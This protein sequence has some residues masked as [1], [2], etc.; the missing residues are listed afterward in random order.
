MPGKPLQSVVNMNLEVLAS[1][2]TTRLASPLP[3]DAAHQL[4]R[5]RALDGNFPG[6]T[7]KLPPKPG[8][9][10]ILLYQE[11]DAVRFPIIRRQVYPGAHSGQISLPGGKTERGESSIVTAL[12]E[13]HEEIGVDPDTP[14]VIGA[15]S[16]FF[17]GASNFMITPIVATLDH[18]PTFHPDAHEVAAVL[19]AD[20]ASLLD[21]HAI[22]EAEIVAA[23]NYKMMA[24][25]FLLDNAVV[26]GATAMILNEFRT[27]LRDLQ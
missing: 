14:C 24:P 22:L 18:I 3:G 6:F 16:D 25:H 17:V 1:Q 10:M 11:G 13:T 15:L 26:W 19:S 21:D 27:I 23:G 12:R 5:A 20:L 2:L 8:A 9:V 7:H 4:M